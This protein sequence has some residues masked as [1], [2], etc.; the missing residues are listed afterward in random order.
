MPN[1]VLEQTRDRVLRYGAVV[2]RELLSLA[3]SRRQGCHRSRC[4]PGG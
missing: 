2:G 3:R 4:R 1:L